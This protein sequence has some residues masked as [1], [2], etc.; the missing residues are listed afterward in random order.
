M[1]KRNFHAE[2]KMIGVI[3]VSKKKRGDIIA[4]SDDSFGAANYAEYSVARAKEGKYKTARLISILVYALFPVLMI[5][6]AMAVNAVVKGIGF[7]LIMTAGALS[8]LIIW[9][10]V[11][12][13]WPFFSQSYHYEIEGAAMTGTLHYGARYE[14]TL[15]S[16]KIRDM[17]AIVP[18]SAHRSEADSYVS[19]GA[20]VI[21]CASSMKAGDLYF[22]R[23]EESDTVI[24]FEATEQSL[25]ALKYYNSDAI[26]IV[27]TAR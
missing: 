6:A 16:V 20:N 5:S 17:K 18:Y 23:I 12:F 8:P 2:N 26:E 10:L 21:M 9:I 11:F 19:K 14:K 7:V 1:N 24:F 27:K 25:R 13:T 22:A 15:F 3:K 4:K